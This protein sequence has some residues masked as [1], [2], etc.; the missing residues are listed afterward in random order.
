[1]LE[2]VLVG[3]LSG[4]HLLIEGVPGLAKTLTIKSSAPCSAAVPSH[5]V[6]ARSRAG[7]PR[8]HAYLQTREA[9]SSTPSPARSSP[10][11][12][13]PTRST[14][15]RQG[16]VGA[17]RGDAG[18]PGDD[19]RHD[20]TRC[21]IRSLSW[22]RRTRSSRRAPI[23]SPRRRSTASCSRSWS[24]IRPGRGADGRAAIARGGRSKFGISCRSR[25]SA[26]CSAPR[27]MC[28]SIPRSSRTRSPSRRRRAI[29]LRQGWRSSAASLSTAP[30]RVGRSR[31]CRAEGAGVDPRTR[32]RAGRG[33]ARAGE[34]RPSPQARPHLP[35]ARRAAHRGRCA[36]CGA[37]AFPAP[38]LELGRP[39]AA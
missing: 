11:S 20:A 27:S 22:R 16:P 14:A 23:R 17:A 10:T 19:R 24:A 9:A 28:T 5:P 12:C 36:R 6:H 39:M 32:L 3:L 7:R 26:R 37:G 1:M 30:A 33:S 34:G 15:R 2:R 18:A 21:R 13:W 8:R 35:G 25:V 31:S 29:R 38:P 4:G